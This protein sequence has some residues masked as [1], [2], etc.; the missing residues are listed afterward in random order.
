MLIAALA[1]ATAALAGDSL[2]AQTQPYRAS[3]CQGDAPIGVSFGTR[4][5]P[6]LPGFVIGSVS[7]SGFA[8]ACL[9][10]PGGSH[11][12][13]VVLRLGPPSPGRQDLEARTITGRAV[14][15]TLP[16][17]SQPP[18]AALAG[19]RVIIR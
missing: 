13:Q 7:L 3:A 17:G 2:A 5:D 18:A 1:L 11:T 19:V 4:F 15:Y 6:S 10:T 16:E 9:S 14:V 8:S 12:A